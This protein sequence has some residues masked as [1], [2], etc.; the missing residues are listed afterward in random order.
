M[1]S[2]DQIAISMSA[3]HHQRHGML[4]GSSQQTSSS[5]GA[6]PQAS[7]SQPSFLAGSQPQN[8]Y[9]RGQ[10]AMGRSHASLGG[11]QMPTLSQGFSQPPGRPSSAPQHL[12]VPSSSQQTYAPTWSQSQP[13]DDWYAAPQQP[14]LP[15]A[16]AA[17]RAGGAMGRRQGGD[18]RPGSAPDASQLAAAAAAAR[19]G[20]LL[21]GGGGALAE[22]RGGGA[23]AALAAAGAH[24]LLQDADAGRDLPRRPALSAGRLEAPDAAALAPQRA[25]GAAPAGGAA[26]DAEAA[27]ALGAGLS[28]LGARMG[29]LEERWAKLADGVGEVQGALALHLARL[30]GVSAAC[31]EVRAS[32]ERLAGAVAGVSDGLQLLG[33]QQQEERT[34]REELVRRAAEAAAAAAAAPPPWRGAYDGADAACQTG[35]RLWACGGA[36]GPPA[37]VAPAAA[38]AAPCGRATA[39]GA[40]GR[41]GGAAP[42]QRPPSTAAG[43]AG[44]KGTGM[45][46]RTR[47][48]SP[49]PSHTHSGSQKRPAS[50]GGSK[51]AKAG[52][53]AKAAP[54]A[55]PPSGAKKAAGG[56]GARALQ[57]AAGMRGQQLLCFP[58]APAPAAAAAMSAPLPRA[59][60]QP[61][62]KAPL[63]S[64]HR[65]PLRPLHGQA[66]P[67]Q[68]RALSAGGRGKRSS[69]EASSGPSAAAAHIALFGGAAAPPAGRGRQGAGG[70]GW[71]GGRRSSLGSDDVSSGRGAALSSGDGDDD[72][73]EDDEEAI[74]RQLAARL[75]SHRSKRLR[76][77]LGAAPS[78]SQW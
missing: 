39:G 44:A 60:S 66:Q 15:M 12:Q 30:D 50:G 65:E 61:P 6:L 43:A 36:G 76:R 74:A 23:A 59:G 33:R 72:E 75:A 46:L 51:G 3:H 9:S 19:G 34:A 57:Q 37:A 58:K 35:G 54:S 2:R 41:Q 1:R 77:S 16:V 69:P 8:P 53:A 13:T 28:Q 45:T 48:P 20:S 73:G 7:M 10:G 47:S 26:L 38:P 14:A 17:L 68:P 55:A 27:A 67:Q 64:Q 70:C 24:S 32:V 78:A 42:A 25:R 49:G 22:R 56:R 71:A 5:F 29:A 31:G 40:G 4:L 21:G 62:L 63:M 18:G 52:A 11:S